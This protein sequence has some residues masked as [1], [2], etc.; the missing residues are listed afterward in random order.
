MQG[1]V[2]GIRRMTDTPGGEAGF[3]YRVLEF[4][5]VA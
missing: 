2:S 5:R 4:E 3:F 1:N